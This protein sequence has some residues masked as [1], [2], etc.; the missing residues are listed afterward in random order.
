MGT[1]LPLIHR[2][3]T[4]DLEFTERASYLAVEIILLDMLRVHVEDV[5]GV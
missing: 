2:S 5:F 3:E 4:I 1:P